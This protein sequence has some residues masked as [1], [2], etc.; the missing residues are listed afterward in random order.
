LIATKPALQLYPA[1]KTFPGTPDVELPE[2]VNILE[3]VDVVGSANGLTV[4]L[5][6]NPQLKHLFISAKKY[7]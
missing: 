4:K 1:Y 6:F 3:S 7:P 2:Q 5:A